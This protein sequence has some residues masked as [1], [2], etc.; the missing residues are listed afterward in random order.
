M[1]FTPPFTLDNVSILYYSIEISN[2]SSSVKIAISTLLEY[3][4]TLASNC[5]IY[6]VTITPHNGLGAGMSQMLDFILYGGQM[7]LISTC[8]ECFN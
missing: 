1:T 5:E 6:T 2:S 8:H 4:V 7:I 3:N